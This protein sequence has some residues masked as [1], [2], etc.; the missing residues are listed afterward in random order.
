MIT[1]TN[2]S[3]FVQRF[4]VCYRDMPD[5]TPTASVAPS[6]STSPAYEPPRLQPL[7]SWEVITLAQS[8]PIGPGALLQPQGFKDY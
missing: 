6:T 5:S 4:R 2:L 3:H 7:G 1:Y 8:V